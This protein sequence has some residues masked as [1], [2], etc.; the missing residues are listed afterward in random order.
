M[1]PHGN[2]GAFLVGDE[3]PKTSQGQIEGSLVCA[4]LDSAAPEAAHVRNIGSSETDDDQPS[5]R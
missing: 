4:V 3:T 5:W 2:L 1:P